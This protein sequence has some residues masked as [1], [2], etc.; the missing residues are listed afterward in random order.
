MF[1]VTGVAV[2]QTHVLAAMRDAYLKEVMAIQFLNIKNRFMA[3]DDTRMRQA[4]YNRWHQHNLNLLTDEKDSY[5]CAGAS[6]CVALFWRQQSL[7][8]CF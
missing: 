3:L 5:T 2:A 4:T 7:R 6:C 1:V 8:A